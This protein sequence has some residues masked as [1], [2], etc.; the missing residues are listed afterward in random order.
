MDLKIRNSAVIFMV[1]TMITFVAIMFLNT[2]PKIDCDDPQSW[3]TA[4]GVRQCAIIPE[5]E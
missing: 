3:S 5:G 1:V 2:L 4:Y